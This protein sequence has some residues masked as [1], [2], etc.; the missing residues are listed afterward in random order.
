MRIK[1]LWLALFAASAVGAACGEGHVIF[2][3]DV[4]SFLSGAKNDTLHYT[5]PATLGGTT[6]IPPIKVNLLS[7]SGSSKVDTVVI[8]GSAAVHNLTG[9]PGK[10]VFRLYFA[11]DSNAVYTSVPVLADSSGAGP[12]A[13]DSTMVF[14]ATLTAATDSL[15]LQP[16][17]F[18]GMKATVTNP[19]ATTLDGKLQLTA[20]NLR[21]VIADKIF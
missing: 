1:R 8:S 17:L 5:V 14:S 7:G 15:F 10:L 16:H 18:V 2:N 6:Q 4:F 20:L 19:S 21:V 11:A 13:V 3:I 12:G 9:G